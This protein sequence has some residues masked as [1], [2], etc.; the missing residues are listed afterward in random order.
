MMPESSPA[1]YFLT[2]GINLVYFIT[3]NVQSLVIPAVLQRIY[4]ELKVQSLS[5]TCPYNNPSLPPLNLV[6]TFSRHNHN[7]RTHINA[8]LSLSASLC[9]GFH[10]SFDSP[11]PELLNPQI[12]I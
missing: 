11:Q 12:L 7:T 3:Q 6:F 2:F 8:T 4:K 5:P 1:V 10:I 9:H